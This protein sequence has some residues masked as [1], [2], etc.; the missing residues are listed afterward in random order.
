MCNEKEIKRKQDL[1]QRQLQITV[2][3]RLERNLDI[4]IQIEAQTQRIA[5]VV[6]LAFVIP[7]RAARDV[8]QRLA[9]RVGQPRCRVRDASDGQQLAVAGPLQLLTA[10]LLLR[11]VAV[12]VV[13]VLG[14]RWGRLLGLLGLFG[15]AASAWLFGWWCGGH[16]G[17]FCCVLKIGMCRVVELLCC[18]TFR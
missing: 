6:V 14:W 17:R 2:N 5:L 12:L 8:A 1:Q 3:P 16:G 4:Q 13:A 10:L 7:E 15:R 9:R 18:S 11:L